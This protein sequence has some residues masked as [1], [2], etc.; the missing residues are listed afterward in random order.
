[1]KRILIT[2]G[3]RDPICPVPQ[4]QALADWLKGQGADVTLFWHDGGHELRQEEL[5]AMRDFFAA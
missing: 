5:L 3:R 4:T 2:A 1:M